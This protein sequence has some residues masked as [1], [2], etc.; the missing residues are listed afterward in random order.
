MARFNGAATDRSRKCGGTGSVCGAAGGFNG[1][2][3][4]RSR[5][6]LR[7]PGP[8]RG[9]DE[10]SMGPRPI[11]RG[12]PSW[13]SCNR[14]RPSGF[15]GAAT[16]RSRK[17]PSAS[18][19]ALGVSQASMGPRPI[20]RGNFKGFDPDA[21]LSARASMGPRPIGRGNRSRLRSTGR[22][23]CASMGP[24]PIGRGNMGT[25]ERPDSLQV[26]FNGAA[27]DRSRK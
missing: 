27:T 17:L 24:R 8:S 25:L 7:I 5:K 10:A 22:R 18:C 12:N 14:S 21:A 2:A 13:C 15:N 23:S 19:R 16:D 4:D 26:G 1:A 6:F 3:T 20:G 9:A 11:G